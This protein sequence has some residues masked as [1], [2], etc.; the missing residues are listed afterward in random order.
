MEQIQQL[1]EILKQTPE[2]ALWALTAYFL[3]II[4]KLASWV[5]ALK[6]I[7]QQLIKRFFD[8]REK[9]LNNKRGVEIAEMFEANKISNVDYNLLIELLQAVKKENNYFFES[10]IREAINKLS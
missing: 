7:F 4:I 5:Y 2:M 10:D 9:A 1:L 3:F 8:Y 6:M